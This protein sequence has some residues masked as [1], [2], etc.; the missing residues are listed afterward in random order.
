MES[1]DR[2]T[3]IRLKIEALLKAQHQLQRDLEAQQA[4]N[5][6]LTQKLEEYQKENR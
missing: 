5:A 2:L 1:G 3:L 4:L 6:L